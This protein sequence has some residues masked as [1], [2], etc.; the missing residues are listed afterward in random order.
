MISFDSNMKLHYL[1]F[2]VGSIASAALVTFK[3]NKINSLGIAPI[4][5]S[6]RLLPDGEEVIPAKKI[7]RP[8]FEESDKLEATKLNGDVDFYEPQSDVTF[9]EGKTLTLSGEFNACNKISHRS[10]IG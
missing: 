2:L 10:D 8:F 3:Y 6:W 5:R 9:D 4:Y 1:G 7:T